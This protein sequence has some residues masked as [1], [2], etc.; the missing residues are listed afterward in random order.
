MNR[1]GVSYDIGRMMGVNW[2]PVF[3]LKVVHRELEIIRTD[4]H[5]NAVRI[6]GLDIDRL[7]TA[8]ADALGQGLEVWLTPEMWDKS[9]DTTLA[10]ITK[11]A[12]AAEEL[13]QRWPDRLV[14]VVGSE[15]T[16][17][18]QGIV[19][20]KNI[21]ARM[22]N[23]L[24]WEGAK[25]GTHN[26]PLNAFLGRAVEA[27]R[28]VY[29][30]PVSY[31]SLVWEAVDW[32]RFDIIGVDHYRDRRI[33][34]RYVD[35]L[36]PLFAHGKPVVVTEF[37]CRTFQGAD[38]AGGIGS[39][40]MVDNKTLFLHQLPLVGRLVRPRLAGKYVRDEALPARELRETLGILDRACVDGAF[41]MTFVA[42]IA[43]YDEDRRYDLDMSSFALVKTYADGRHGTTYPDMPWEPKESF[44]AVAESYARMDAGD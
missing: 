20:G 18:M 8:A 27:V 26:T 38:G 30:G 37:G 43:P 16:L 31:A 2:R 34:D 23:P 33:N 32:S 25:A 35:M 10:Y 17:F 44:R 42:P 7:T 12:A 39:F 41:V 21:V 3:D 40:G 19:P 13:R 24:F 6:C 15:L 14:F 29:H 9:P 1:R 22:R 28:R 36:G 4:L 5:C 11:A